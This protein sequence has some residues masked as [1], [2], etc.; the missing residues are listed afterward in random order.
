MDLTL[1]HVPFAYH[2]LDEITAEFDRLG[3]SPDYGGVH[4]NG[5]THMAVLGFDDRSY[6]E[7]IAERGDGDHD[8]WPEYIRAD[9]GP[10]DWCVRVPDI[11]AECKRYLDAGYAVRGPLYGSRERDDG[12]LV[13]WDRAEFGGDDGLLPFAIEDRTPLSARVAPSESVAGGPLT[14]LGQVVLGVADLDAAVRRFREHHR[15]PE[16]VEE[17]VPRFGT[18]ASFPGR[19]VALAAPEGEGWL[20]DRIAAFGDGPCACLLA[21]DDLDAARDAYPL[22]EPESWPDGEVA[23]FDS[24]L[25]GSRLGVVEREET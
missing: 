25:L 17:T 21:T 15:F 18:V 20:A 6:V 9:A 13:E 2:D 10:A 11:V 12:R 19:P 23:T 14:G 4:D 8:F 24:D 22:R 5:V 3:L 7:L 16:P 1:D